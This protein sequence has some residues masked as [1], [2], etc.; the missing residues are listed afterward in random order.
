V[1]GAN[2]T[3]EKFRLMWSARCPETPPISYLFKHRLP[4]RWAPI[5]SLQASKRY[6]D[7]KPDWDE[8]L[9]R[10]NSVIDY[11]VPPGTLIDVVINCAKLE[12][13]LFRSFDPVDIGTFVDAENDCKF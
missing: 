1:S 3:R 13:N 10:Q 6:A 12:N 9:H 5:H 8:L 7:T 4:Q 11:L 2:A